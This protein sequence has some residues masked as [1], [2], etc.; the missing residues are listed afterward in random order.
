MEVATL[1]ISL[2]SLM[3][4]NRDLKAVIEQGRSNGID[5]GEIIVRLMTLGAQIC[6]KIL[7]DVAMGAP[8]KPG[9]FV[10]I[11]RIAHD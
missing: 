7:L 3:D 6:D 1:R 9:Q 2:N 10:P 5:D 4:L 8:A 11:G